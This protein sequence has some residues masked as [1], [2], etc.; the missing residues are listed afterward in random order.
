MLVK[1]PGDIFLLD[2]AL[3]HE[4]VL[5]PSIICVATFVKQRS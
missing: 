1:I 3:S 4:K 2:I 5:V